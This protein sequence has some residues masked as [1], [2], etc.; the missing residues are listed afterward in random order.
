MTAALL[1]LGVLQVFTGFVLLAKVPAMRRLD[2][3]RDTGLTS[4]YR[5]W[6][7]TAG[8]IGCTALA[9]AVLL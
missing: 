8:L 7:V 5:N 6:G 1:T 2:A 4:L 9:L 3:R